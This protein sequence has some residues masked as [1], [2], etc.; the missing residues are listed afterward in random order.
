[1]SKLRY[2][3]LTFVALAV[4]CASSVQAAAPLKYADPAGD[5]IDGR[6]SMDIVSVTHDL[7]QINRTG[8]KSL[9]FE[10]ELAA[11]PEPIL[12]SYHVVTV[13]E[14]CGN[15]Y[16]NFRPGALLLGT[17]AIPNAD[18]WVSCGGDAE[19]L[20][21]QFKITGNVLRWATALDSLPKDYRNG[22]LTNL[23]AVTSIAEPV[24]GVYGTARLDGARGPLPIDQATSEDIWE[25]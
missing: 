5:A 13:L 21:T 8:P 23:S 9:V 4:L 22:V 18:I 3:G 1:M 19:R 11:P 24:I 15:L 12:A 17:I 6:P 16:A 25:Y 7:R 20:S 2:A 10:L 14:G